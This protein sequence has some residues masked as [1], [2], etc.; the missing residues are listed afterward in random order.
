MFLPEVVIPTTLTVARVKLRRAWNRLILRGF[1]LAGVHHHAQIVLLAQLALV[2]QT[3]LGLFNGFAS[4]VLIASWRLAG[5]ILPFVIAQAAP[6]PETT[7][8]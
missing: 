7:D 4:I 8:G 1:T 6:S 2:A 3:G 5:I